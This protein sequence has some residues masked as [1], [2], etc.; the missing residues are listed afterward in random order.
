MIRSG[1]ERLIS[2]AAR[3]GN[4][5]FFPTSEFP[6][7]A[8]VESSWRDILAELDGLLT[9]PE[10]IPAFQEVSPD[11]A[12]LTQGTDW[13]TFF[14]YAYGRT[15]EEN[16]ARCPRTVEILARIPG[17]TTAMFSI[18]APG[19]HIP[20]H[21]GPYKGVLRYH[22]GLVIPDQ[23]ASCRIRVGNDIRHWEAGKSLIFD[24]AHPHEVWNETAQRRV[25]LFV[26]FERPL[27][28]PVSTLNRAVIRRIAKTNYVTSAVD[29]IKQLGERH[30]A[31][32]R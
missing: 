11:Q 24:D 10:T 30:T 15:L 18:L 8:A 4:R 3:D 7:A 32:T 2:F 12:R 23:A 9:R 20:Q 31:K 19:K 25:V 29:T 1:L 6:W 13:K 26:D 27:P 5:T 28:F 17:M 14:L 16:C 22:L 21:R